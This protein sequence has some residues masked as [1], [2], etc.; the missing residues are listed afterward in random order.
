MAKVH[1]IRGNYG[2]I[3]GTSTYDAYVSCSDMDTHWALQNLLPGIDNGRLDEEFGGTF[4]LYYEDRDS[5][6]S[7][8]AYS[9]N[10]YQPNG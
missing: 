10:M 4:R 5:N 3:E 8:L 9:I 1:D 7:K 6:P 2:A